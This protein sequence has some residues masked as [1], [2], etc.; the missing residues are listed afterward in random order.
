MPIDPRIPLGAIV[1]QM[2]DPMVTLGRIGQLRAQR[3]AEEDH[4][5]D[6]K[7]RLDSIARADKVRDLLA[8]AYANSPDGNLDLDSVAKQ[9]MT[10]DPEVALKLQTEAAQRRRL[11][12][13]D[14]A[15][16]LEHR[17]K[18]IHERSQIL[19]GAHDQGTYDNALA[20]LKEIG[21]DTS[22]MNPTYDKKTVDGWVDQ[23]MTFVER[24]QMEAARYRAETVKSYQT[25]TI[26][27]Q[28][29]PVEVPFDPD[30][31]MFHLPDGSTAKFAPGWVAPKEKTD[32]EPRFREVSHADGSQTLEPERGGMVTREPGAGGIT[33]A[34]KQTAERWKQNELSKLETAMQ[35]G[36]DDGAPMSEDDITNAKLRIQNGYLAQLGQPAETVLGPEWNSKGRQTP[37]P[38]APPAK[39]QAAAKKGDRRLINGQ[40]AVW[41]GKGWAPVGNGTK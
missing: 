28:G 3:E 8:G 11:K 14:D 22:K 21:A 34:Q 6:R 26:N 29:K 41:D 10:V 13:A 39:K 2:D 37:P 33:A 17:S 12:A 24:A 15:A 40:P 20:G 31:S 9:V 27:W 7:E 19:A 16:D 4:R 25:R 38:A 35:R 36:R 32:R 23:G 30:T 1:P 18:R 5:I